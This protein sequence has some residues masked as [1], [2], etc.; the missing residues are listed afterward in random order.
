[1]VLFTYDANSQYDM[2]TATPQ[3]QTKDK[4]FDT[5]SA[6]LP[7]TLPIPSNIFALGSW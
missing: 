5:R 7:A 6:A 1:M 4:V 3:H 2:A